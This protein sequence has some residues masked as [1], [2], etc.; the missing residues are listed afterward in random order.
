MLLYIKI[1]YTL[2]YYI[3]NMY[4]MSLY[5]V[6]HV[7][8]IYNKNKIKFTEYKL[9]PVVQITLINTHLALIKNP[10]RSHLLIIY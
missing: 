10:H 2:Q 3:Y 1:H 7:Y 8:I 5:Y 9:Q 6:Y 4:Y